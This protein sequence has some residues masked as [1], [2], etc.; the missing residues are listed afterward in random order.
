MDILDQHY[1]LY[2]YDFADFELFFGQR[3]KLRSLIHTRSLQKSHPSTYT[4]QLLISTKFSR[5]ITTVIF[6]HQ[7]SQFSFY[8]DLRFVCFTFAFGGG[9]GVG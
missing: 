1:Y 5:R 7:V 9:V 8:F 2:A 4:S 3:L 6:H